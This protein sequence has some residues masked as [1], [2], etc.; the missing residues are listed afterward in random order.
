MG[1]RSKQTLLQRRHTDNEEAH[2]K[3]FSITNYQKN[4][5]EELQRGTI[6]DWSKWPSKKL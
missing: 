2:E 1:R 4:A 6:S 3:M 5:N